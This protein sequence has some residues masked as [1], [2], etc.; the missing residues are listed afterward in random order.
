MKR[1]T[2][3]LTGAVLAALGIT[4]VMARTGE[5]AAEDRFRA[6]FERWYRLNP[7]STAEPAPDD[8]ALLERHTPVYYLGASAQNPV[9]FYAGY[10]AHGT[11]YDA[12]GNV[13]ATHPDRATLNAHAH[14]PGMRFVHDGPSAATGP[15]AVYG[16]ID[17]DTM[18]FPDGDHPLLFLHYT[19]VFEVSGLPFGLSAVQEFAARLVADP[20]DW[21]QLDH[22]V[23]VTIVLDEAGGARS[24]LAAI[25]QQHNDMRT[26]RLG[27]AEG[28]GQL[29]WPQDGR[30]GVDIALRSNEAYPHRAAAT[31]WRCASFMEGRSARWLILGQNRPLTAAEDVTDPAR[32]L[33]NLPLVTLPP[34]DAFYTF[35]GSLGAA[36]LL[37]GRSGPPG[38]DFNTLAS[39][40]RPTVQLTVSYWYEGLTS[41]VDE[42]DVVSAAA[43]YGNDIDISPFLARFHADWRGAGG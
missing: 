29:T 15:G 27:G 36:R 7:P 1:R 38:A 9:D 16:R 11:L 12:A 39:L 10:I 18:P 26:W 42:I 37:P 23:N 35:L 24:P 22:Y 3:L 43:W 5:G 31:R 6:Q 41:Y 8:R 33:D 25:F 21:H 30:L 40:K 28:P 13:V 4:L 20:G 32:R 2:W 14:D 34:S 17:R 19:L